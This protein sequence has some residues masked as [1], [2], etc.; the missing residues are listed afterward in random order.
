MPRQFR[1]ILS[2]N[3]DI[4][5]RFVMEAASSFRHLDHTQDGD[6]GLTL[7]LFSLGPASGQKTI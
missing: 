4:Y 3:A 6:L 5:F 1:S 7:T 2:R